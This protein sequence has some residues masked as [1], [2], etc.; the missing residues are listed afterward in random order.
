M[1]HGVGTFI[2]QI[3]TMKYLPAEAYERY[4]LG[5]RATAADF[6]DARYQGGTKGH[7]GDPPLHPIRPNVCADNSARGAG[8]AWAE[9]GNR[10]RVTDGSKRA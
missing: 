2:F 8:H 1:L 9:G 6:V 7:A 5:D 3:E 4:D 10:D